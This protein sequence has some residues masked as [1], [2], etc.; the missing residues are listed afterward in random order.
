MKALKLKKLFLWTAVLLFTM[1]VAVS[2]AFGVIGAI[3]TGKPAEAAGGP[4]IVL[5]CSPEQ[6]PSTDMFQEFIITVRI[7]GVSSVAEG[8]FGANVRITPVEKESLIF[9]GFIASSDVPQSALMPES[10]EGEFI[11][12]EGIN[13]N[14]AIKND[15]NVGQYK[16]KLKT[17]ETLD[18][19][20]FEFEDNGCASWFGDALELD[21]GTYAVQFR[22]AETD[23]TLSGLS[24]S[25]NG[26]VII[27]SIA[28][29]QT[30]EEEIPYGDRELK[31]S[32]TRGGKFAKIK[33]VDSVNNKTL[34]VEDAKDLNNQSLGKL[35]PGEHTLTITVTSESG[36]AKTYKVS[37][38]VGEAP[39]PAE[40]FL[41]KPSDQPG[42]PSGGN[43]YTGN[44][45]D[46]TPDGMADLAGKV[47]FK[48]IN[49]DGSESPATINDFKPTNAGSYKIVATPKDGFFW[50]GGGT[51]P[52]EYS[53]E[54]GKA[55]ITATSGGEGKKPNFSSESFKG[56]F[57]EVVDYK[58]YSDE[59]CTQEIAKS[60][61]E[62]GQTYYAKPVLKAGADANFEFGDDAAT[63]K[64]VNDGFPYVEPVAGSDNFFTKKFLGLP[65]WAWL[66][67]LLVILLLIIILIIV[68]K[69]K[70]NDDE[71]KIRNN[72]V[73]GGA[74]V[75]AIA[76]DSALS[77]RTEKLDD[78]LRSM[79]DKAHEREITRYREEVERAKRDAELKNAA[80]T[81]GAGVAADTALSMKTERL[82][83]RLREMERQARDREREIE[84]EA[85]E[86]E[87]ARYK[88][89]VEKAKKEAELKNAANTAAAVA[90][91]VAA[92]TIA[93]SAF[94]SRA[95]KLEERIRE[96][97]R[98]ARDRQHEIEREAYERELARY[99]EELAKVKMDASAA[100]T[101]AGAVAGTTVPSDASNLRIAQ[102]EDELRR[103]QERMHDEMRRRD[104]EQRAA[105]RRTTEERIAQMKLE[106]EREVERIREEARRNNGAGA[107]NQPQAAAFA[108]TEMIARLSQLEDNMKRRE[109]AMREEM[110]RQQDAQRESEHKAAEERIAQMKSEAQREIERLKQEAR[111]TAKAMNQ[112][113]AAVL[114]SNDMVARFAQLEEGFKR[115]EEEMREQMRRQEEAQ[116]ESERKNAEAR[117]AQMKADAE[118]EA[119]RIKEEAERLKEE[120]RKTAEDIKHQS[121]IAAN[122][123]PI[124][125][126]G[127]HIK[128]E[129]DM[130]AETAAVLRD[131]QDRMRKMEQELQEQRMTNL[132][133]ENTEKA[134]KE[135]EEASKMRRHEEEMQRLRDLQDYERRQRQEMQNMPYMQGMPN[136][137]YMPQQPYGGQY[138]APDAFMRQQQ[139]FEAQRLKLL[140][141]RLK[142]REMEVQMLRSQSFGMPQQPYGG[143]PYP[144]YGQPQPGYAPVQPGYAP[145]PYDPM[146]GKK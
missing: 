52:I 70:K 59:G 100:A 122:R 146:G 48:K 80:A 114:A 8:M 84:H 106:A 116:R 4:K 60:D 3:N 91:A 124:A 44:S 86:R 12:M 47:D 9:I 42:E 35:D 56:S 126:A 16:F 88:E 39:P 101:T 5:K 19:L 99:K 79:E 41:P 117:I 27:D 62:P 45:I 140:E 110:R 111:E 43:A 97:E 28:D 112:P 125:A 115:R 145:N 67:I 85:Y 68:L 107:Y 132:M 36:D 138:G 103:Y 6:I 92:G 98:E 23:N 1:I 77:A 34:F 120:A 129:G 65:V 54:V 90:P 46:F 30:V 10:V 113:Q 29:E 32:A 49:P 13:P 104:D 18:A 38:K 31:I 14:T 63:Q 94:A 135:M 119:M 53:F 130:D 73:A 37:L 24:I 22:D 75:A 142:Q 89:E 118:R 128:T 58:Y 102:L 78:R 82:E 40:S 109:E 143:Q 74:G 15:F 144:V 134:R 50:D 71:D 11:V 87:V 123:Q 66:V 95:E 17:G 55:K 61:L 2:L 136:M 131:Y 69:K 33:V 81:A 20:H 139:D 141:E 137:Q 21:G 76:A 96:M 64:F 26:N 93:D 51:D 7:E 127:L 57:D 83:E 108:T 72:G 105:E 25:A 133:R 121:E